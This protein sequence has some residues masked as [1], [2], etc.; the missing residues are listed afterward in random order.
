MA[1]RRGEDSDEAL[2]GAM[3]EAE[4]FRCQRFICAFFEGLANARAAPS[5]R[6]RGR[7]GQ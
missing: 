1:Y 4:A 7:R 5:R 2:T 3:L 6:K